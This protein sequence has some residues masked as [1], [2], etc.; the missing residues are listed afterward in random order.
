[1]DYIKLVTSIKANFKDGLSYVHGK[2]VIVK[3]TILMLMKK[4][5]KANYFNNGYEY[6]LLDNDEKIPLNYASS[7]QQDALWLLNIMFYYLTSD[8]KAFFII[9]EPESHFYPETQKLITEFIALVHNAGHKILI[10]THS[11]YILGA[12]D[13]LLYAQTRANETGKGNY[14]SENIIYK[15]YW[16]KKESFGSWFVSNG[17][18]ESCFNEETGALKNGVIDGISNVIN[19]DFDKLLN[20]DEVE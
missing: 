19:E 14:I 16:L 2:P 17:K 8:S 18:A 15:G 6:L 3:A 13:N 5:L 4:I 9:E 10:T 12:L 1:M 11:P 7:G 20:V